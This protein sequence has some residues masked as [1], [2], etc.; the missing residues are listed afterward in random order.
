MMR[1][2]H[3]FCTKKINHYKK[4]RNRFRVFFYTD[5]ISY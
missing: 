1:T 5:S 3:L 4:L 2:L